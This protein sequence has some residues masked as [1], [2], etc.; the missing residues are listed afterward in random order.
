ML[1]EEVCYMGLIWEIISVYASS[2][3]YYRVTHHKIRMNERQNYASEILCKKYWMPQVIIKTWSRIYLAYIGISA[4]ILDTTKMG[5]WHVWIYVIKAAF[6][7]AV[8]NE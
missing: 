5:P 2:E 4:V 6:I 7:Q 1:S 3:P 8:I